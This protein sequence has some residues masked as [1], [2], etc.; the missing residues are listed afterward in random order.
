M[1]RT[2]IVS[3]LLL[4]SLVQAAPSCGIVQGGATYDLSEL[5]LPN[6]HF[7]VHF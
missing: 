6:S 3:A 1:L 7:E 2:L 4:A 5:A